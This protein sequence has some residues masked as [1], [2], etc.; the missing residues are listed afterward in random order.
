M[1]GRSSDCPCKLC[2]PPNRH[3]GCHAKCE[4]YQ[5]W[6]GIIREAVE[7]LKRE[8]DAIARVNES[9]YNRTKR[10]KR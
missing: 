6:H 5:E 9:N 10:R 1:T 8:G 2:M 4:A 7:G 3:H